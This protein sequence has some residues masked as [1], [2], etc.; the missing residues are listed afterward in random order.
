MG[1]YLSSTRQNSRYINRQGGTSMKIF[2]TLVILFGLALLLVADLPAAH[3][4]EWDKTTKI[5]FKEPVQVPGKVLPAGTYIF[6]LLDSTSN[7]HVVQIFNEDH[8]SLITTVMAIPNERLGPAGKTILAYDERPADQPMALAAWFYPGDNFGQ[9]FVYPKSEAEQLSRL[10][11][12][13]VPSGEDEHPKLQERNTE[14]ASEKPAAAPPIEQPKLEPQNPPAVAA[15][16]TPPAN[17]EVAAQ[18][19]PQLPHTASSLPLIGLVGL[20][21]LGMA[22][23]L[24]MAL[25]R[26]QR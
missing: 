15:N 24:R 21:L 22:V 8:T 4:D 11:N 12:R 1:A 9:E 14:A 10:N 26:N 5:T 23:V 17:T 19:E 13:E 18:H 20:T 2:R 6:K 25:R 3:A 16:P 7:R